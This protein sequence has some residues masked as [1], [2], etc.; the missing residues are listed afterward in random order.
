MQLKG[1]NAKRIFAPLPKIYI[2]IMYIKEREERWILSQSGF[3]WAMG[4]EFLGKVL[5]KNLK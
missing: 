1:T 5:G 3:K 4:Y 2:N